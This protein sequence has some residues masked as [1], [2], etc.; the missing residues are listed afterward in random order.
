[1]GPYP[2]P[3]F[4]PRIQNNQKIGLS[5]EWGGRVLPSPPGGATT[6]YGSLSVEYD[7]CGFG[8]VWKC[9]VIRRIQEL[10]FNVVLSER[11]TRVD[12][13]NPPLSQESQIGRAS[14]NDV[15]NDE[16]TFLLGPEQVFRAKRFVLRPDYNTPTQ[17]NNDIALVQLD[18]PAILNSRVS[19]VCL[20]SHGYQIPVGSPC[21][22]TGMIMRF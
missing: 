8:G 18:R 12:V 3:I 21:V 1:M 7:R 19:T 22:T 14:Q 15:R 4:S 10:V 6:V 16:F 5:D 2:P 13:G 20:P 17:F 9:Y 11:S